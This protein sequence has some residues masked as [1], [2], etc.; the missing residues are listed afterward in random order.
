MFPVNQKSN[1]KYI[2]TFFIKKFIYKNQKHKNSIKNI[3]FHFFYKY[4]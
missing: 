1:T 2:Y 4:L 3:K